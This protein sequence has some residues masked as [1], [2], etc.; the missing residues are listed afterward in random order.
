ML[1]RINRLTSE[2]DFAGLARSRKSVFGRALGVKMRENALP[3]SRFGIVVGLKVSKRANL[4]N[5]V[6]RRLREIL[7]K[8]LVEFKTGA[9]VMIL[10]NPAAVQTEFADLE[11]QLLTAFKKIGLL[12]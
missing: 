1:K 9:D 7:G 12:K 2:R 8:H 10:A 4:R 5:L 11:T 6:K 3:H